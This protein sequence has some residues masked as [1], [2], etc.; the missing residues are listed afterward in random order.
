MPSSN[1]RLASTRTSGRSKGKAIVIGIVSHPG[2]ERRDQFSATRFPPLHYNI[3][4]L[5]REIS[6]NQTTMILSVEL[7]PEEEALL[8][9]VSRRME[10]DQGD[11]AR[12]AIR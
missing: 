9:E 11:L 4:C 2:V 3:V 1:S 12:Q 8:E 5:S 6:L 10:R 7:T